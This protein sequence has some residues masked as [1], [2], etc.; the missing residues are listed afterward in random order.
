MFMSYTY[1][2]AVLT[3]I[4]LISAVAYKWSFLHTKKIAYISLIQYIYLVVVPGILFSVIFSFIIDVIKK[5]L[6]TEI[7]LSDK[8]LVVLVLL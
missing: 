1:L 2:F 6:N 4:A 8:L 3:I 5:P 7:F